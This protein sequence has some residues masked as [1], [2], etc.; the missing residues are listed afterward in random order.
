MEENMPQTPQTSPT[1]QS[2]EHRFVAIYKCAPR[3]Q[4]ASEIVVADRARISRNADLKRVLGVLQQGMISK[5]EYPSATKPTIRYANFRKTSGNG[6]DQAQTLLN[7]LLSADTDATV[8]KSASDLAK[9]YMSMKNVQKG[10]LI[11]LLSGLQSGKNHTDN[12]LFIFKCDFEDISQ[13]KPKE[14]FRKIEDA[15]EERAKK[16]AQYP[17][18]DGRKFDRKTV[19]VFD[20]LGETQYWLSFLELILPPTQIAKVE[21]ALFSTLSKQHP[22]LIEKYEDVL[23]SVSKERSLSS[24]ARLLESGDLLA[25]NQVQN[26]INTLPGDTLVSLSIDRARVSAP[27]KEYGTKWTIAE[28]DGT[29]FILLKGGQLDVRDNALT[30][31]D[32]GRLV[33]LQQAASALKMAFT[34]R[35]N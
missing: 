19:R 14:I 22:E 4:K 7:S 20:A 27:L 6:T 32:V 13:V 18:F 15:F 9:R 25:P 8:R 28:Q 34:S 21:S 5:R 3:E 17:Y 2:W 12:C 16:G 11:F 24:D 31:F 35:S 30:P 29:Y 26:V 10:V 33:D 23:K 1:T